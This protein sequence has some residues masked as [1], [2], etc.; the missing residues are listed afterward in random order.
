[1]ADSTRRTLWQGAYREPDDRVVPR[2]AFFDAIRRWVPEALQSLRKI[3]LSFSRQGRFI[4]APGSLGP[5]N[6]PEF[7]INVAESERFFVALWEW[8]ASFHLVQGECPFVEVVGGQ[9]PPEAATAAKREDKPR[10]LQ[11]RDASWD[12]SLFWVQVALTQILALLDSE[13]VALYGTMDWLLPEQVITCDMR[14]T[15]Q[16]FDLFLA[17]LLYPYPEN[18]GPDFHFVSPGWNPV[19]EKRGQ[20]RARILSELQTQLDERLDQVEK[21]HQKRGK[22]KVPWKVAVEHFDWLALYQVKGL[23][24][25]RIARDFRPKRCPQTVTHGVRE[26]AKLVIGPRW[27][28]WLRPGLPGRPRKS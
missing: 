9:N 19:H 2:R 23:S 21:T 4:Q 14:A 6:I 7:L 1:M 12:Y 28:Y 8:A 10:D 5:V 25:Q 18:R 16:L 27:K 11:R 15:L 3:V 26:A 13:L 22:E 24:Y 20:A 17:S